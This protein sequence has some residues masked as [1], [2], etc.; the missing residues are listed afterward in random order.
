MS[1]AVLLLVAAVS[2]QESGWKPLPLHA[3]LG[4]VIDANENSRSWIF[5]E[6]PGFTAAR[7]YHHR[8]DWHELHLLRNAAGRGQHLI[9]RHARAEINQMRAGLTQR[10][11]AVAAG[12]TIPARP[13]YEIAEAWWA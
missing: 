2:A 6:I 12:D 7:Y 11:Q 1:N 4:E 3:A 13:L 9:L 5:G 8:N 10:L